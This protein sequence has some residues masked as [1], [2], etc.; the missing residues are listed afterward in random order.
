[1][2]VL[3]NVCNEWVAGEEASVKVSCSDER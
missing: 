2:H 1:V 3:I